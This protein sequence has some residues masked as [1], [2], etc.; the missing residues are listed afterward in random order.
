MLGPRHM[1][2][3]RFLAISV[4]AVAVT[5]CGSVTEPDSQ[6]EDPW[7][8]V[9]AV[10]NNR[11]WI[12]S[13]GFCCIASYDTISGALQITG[14][15]VRLGSSWPTVYLF[16]SHSAGV[17]AFQLR[18]CRENPAFANWWIQGPGKRPRSTDQYG[19][20]TDGTTADS[21]IVEELAVAEARIRGRFHFTAGEL[22]GRGRV[23]ISGRF[24][25]HMSLSGDG[26]WFTNC[27]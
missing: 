11:T 16:V 8:R 2:D 10:I 17:G 24:F 19:Y 13:S 7:N 23:T 20:F 18:K 4:T 21:V 12:S 27:F 3:Y 22:Y 5:S 26:S 1:K 25:G 9:T 6:P 15:E 14:Q